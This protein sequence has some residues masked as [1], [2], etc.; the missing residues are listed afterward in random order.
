MKSNLLLFK[1]IGSKSTHPHTSHVHTLDVV[2]DNLIH[3]S[4]SF[5]CMQGSGWLFLGRASGRWLC[6]TP[7][8][9]FPTS[10]PPGRRPPTSSSP[11]ECTSA[12]FSFS[13]PCWR[14]RERGGG[15]CCVLADSYLLPVT[16]FLAIPRTLG[17][18]GSRWAC[19]CFSA[20]RSRWYS[21]STPA[22][23]SS[24]TEFHM[25]KSS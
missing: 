18:S 1:C 15:C 24:L 13:F 17:S 19:S 11:L 14:R 9:T 4:S 25:K 21:T 10:S 8:Q 5:W 7:S 3:S 20:T 23:S 16:A 22:G 12:S 2:P 6:S